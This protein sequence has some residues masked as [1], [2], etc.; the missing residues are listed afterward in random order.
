MTLLTS[1]LVGINCFVAM[2]KSLAYKRKQRRSQKIKK[3]LERKRRVHDQLKQQLESACGPEPNSEIINDNP[4]VSALS[5]N[6]DSSDCP[7]MTHQQVG[8]EYT[9]VCEKLKLASEHIDYYRSKLKREDERV[10]KRVE[11]I[12]EVMEEACVKRIHSVRHFW[13]D[14]IYNEGTRPG[15]I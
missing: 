7:R 9:S 13:K 11:A 14:K 8:E 6:G 5:N 1:L 10:D 12:R 15:K 3:K 2:G 4:V